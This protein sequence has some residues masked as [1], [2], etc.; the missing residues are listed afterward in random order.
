[1][2]PIALALVVV[3]GIGFLLA[4]NARANSIEVTFIGAVVNG[5]NFDYIYTAKLTPD[6]Y[7]QTGDTVTF[8]DFEGFVSGTFVGDP[9]L[10]GPS[11][12]Q[13]S[14]DDSPI[15]PTL[16][17]ETPPAGDLSIGDIVFTY[18][19]VSPYFLVGNTAPGDVFIGTFILTSSLNTAAFDVVRSTDTSV[20]ADG[21]IGGSGPGA[22]VFNEVNRIT[23]VARSGGF[24]T[25]SIPL[26]LPALAGSALFGMI[27]MGRRK[28]KA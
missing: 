16:S 11:Y 19:G 7:V 17:G 3:C 8:F 12:A 22:D 13:T 6:N 9:L 28:N 1:M 20:G 24:P 26:P 27:G 25:P 14:S 23:T 18:N 15:Q 5:S 2:R 10:G 4:G 21:V